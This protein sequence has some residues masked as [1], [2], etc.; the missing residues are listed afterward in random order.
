MKPIIKTDEENMVALE[1]V[2]RLI[3]ID[4]EPNTKEGQLLELLA[5]QIQEFEK[6]YDLHLENG[7]YRSTGIFSGNRS[8]DS[9]LSELIENSYKKGIEDGLKCI[10]EKTPIDGSDAYE[11]DNAYNSCLRDVKNIIRKLLTD[12]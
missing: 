10:P 11:A 12:K 8:N 9:R 5:E 1:L 6:K 7:V 3:D 4:P 2:E